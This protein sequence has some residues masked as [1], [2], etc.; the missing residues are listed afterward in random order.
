MDGANIGCSCLILF[1][2]RFKTL[3]IASVF[4]CIQCPSPGAANNPMPAVCKNN[5][6]S[7][8][9]KLVCAS[10]MIHSGL[11]LCANQPVQKASMIL[12]PASVPV[13]EMLPVHSGTNIAKFIVKQVIK[14]NL[15]LLC[16]C[17]K[18]SSITSIPTICHGLGCSPIDLFKTIWFPD[19]VATQCGH[20]KFKASSTNH[21][22]NLRSR[23]KR[24]RLLFEGCPAARWSLCKIAFPFSRSSDEIGKSGCAESCCTFSSSICWSFISSDPPTSEKDLFKSAG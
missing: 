2:V 11:G 23:I 6:K 16:C 5:G 15:V 14:R 10:T 9:M 13:A 20:C 8:L 24:A 22:G 17:G 7:P 19:W 18:I 3:T 1:M 4:P 21:F 12:A